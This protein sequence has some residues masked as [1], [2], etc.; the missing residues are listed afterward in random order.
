M[1]VVTARIARAIVLSEVLAR[2]TADVDQTT[3]TCNR[4][5]PLEGGE[6]NEL[7]C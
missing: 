3:Q 6:S 5:N 4:R 2:Y 1:T 7:D